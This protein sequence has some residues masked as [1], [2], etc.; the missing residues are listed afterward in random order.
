[1]AMLTQGRTFGAMRTQV[2]GGIKHGLLAHP[3]TVF[4]DG[5]GGATH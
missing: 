5:V 2:D 3:H 4:H 1:M